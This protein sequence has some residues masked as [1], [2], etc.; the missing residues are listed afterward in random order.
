MDTTSQNQYEGGR[1]FSDSNWNH[2]SF[3]NWKPRGNESCIDGIQST[4]V[5][6]GT[7][8]W[9]PIKALRPNKGLKSHTQGK[10]FA[11]PPSNGPHSY[12]PSSAVHPAGLPASPCSQY[13]CRNPQSWFLR[14]KD[15]G[16]NDIEVT[17]PG[18]L[19][20]IHAKPSVCTWRDKVMGSMSS[21][22][23]WDSQREPAHQFQ[24]LWVCHK[25]LQNLD[26]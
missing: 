1:A 23:P 26:N 20:G 4:I 6:M 24:L 9:C 14:L 2:I 7:S 19:K 11:R 25:L 10:M 5:P 12:V 22:C 15:F 13:R 8:L 16:L 21:R 3:L 17:T 18:E